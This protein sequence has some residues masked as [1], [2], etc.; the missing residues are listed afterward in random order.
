MARFDAGGRFVPLAEHD[1]TRWDAAAIEQAEALLRA[2]SARG[3]PGP[4]QLEAAIQSAHCSRRHGQPIPW[5][6]I[7]AFYEALLRH[8]PSVGAAVGAAVAAVECGRAAEALARLDGLQDAGV[9]DYAPYWAARAHALAAQGEA[10]AARDAWR[11]A[12]GL[13]APG[14]ARD[15]LLA[16]AG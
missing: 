4:F 13:T 16:R 15:F 3:R 6:M 14:A 8:W 11:R 10:G 5:S 2:A 1:T 12:A 7:A 9:A